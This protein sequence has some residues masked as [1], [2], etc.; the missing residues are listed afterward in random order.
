[1]I[2]N[3]EENKK[4]NHPGFLDVYFKVLVI[5]PNDSMY[6]SWYNKN[7]KYN[8]TF[9]DNDVINVKK[10]DYNNWSKYAIK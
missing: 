9:I 1:M 6:I 4:Y 3:F 2:N 5:F 10:E 8:N 7:F